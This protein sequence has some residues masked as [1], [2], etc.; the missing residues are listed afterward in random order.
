MV[1]DM[2]GILIEGT[3]ILYTLT[4][5]YGK[6]LR[7]LKTLCDQIGDTNT[8]NLNLILLGLGTYIFIIKSLS[9]KNRAMIHGVRNISKFKVRRYAA[10]MVKPNAHLDIFTGSKES[11]KNSDKELNEMVLH[12]IPNSWSRQAYFQGFILKLLPLSRLLICLSI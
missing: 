1:L 12:S 3:K 7:E 5:L 8:T 11:D 6:A 10:R 9:K 2:S 4:L